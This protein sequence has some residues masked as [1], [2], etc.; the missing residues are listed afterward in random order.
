MARI[1][2]DGS[3]PA[4]GEAL[5]RL[6]RWRDPRV[7]SLL[8]EQVCHEGRPDATVILA[9]GNHGNPNGLAC[10]L[11]LADCD[12]AR[13]SHAAAYSMGRLGDP[14]ALPALTKLRRHPD[15][16]VR[17]QAVES[18]RWIRAMTR[19]YPDRLNDPQAWWKARS[20]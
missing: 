15:P 10:L 8:E 4:R 2:K 11:K 19:K 1:V 6:V 13:V 9:I 7:L 16:S 5:Q 3:R 14:A 20:S 17:W 18:A 12:D